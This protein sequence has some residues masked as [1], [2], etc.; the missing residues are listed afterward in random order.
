MELLLVGRVLT[1]DPARPEADA[2]AVRGGRVA[3]VGSEAACAREVPGAERIEVPFLSPGFHDAHTHFVDHGVRLLRMRLER[4]ASREEVLRSVAERAKMTPEGG[5]VVGYGWDESKWPDA[6]MPTR[7]DLDRAAPRHPVLLLR[8]D[9]HMA[10]ANSEAMKRAGVWEEDG[11]LRE[12]KAYAAHDSVTPS[13]ETILKG[14]ERA[15]RE[16]WSLG[17]T[18]VHAVVDAE[19]VGVLREAWQAGQLG[20]R[21]GLILREPDAYAPGVAA[22]G[23]E[24]LRVLGVKLFTDGS[25][26]S[27]TAAVSSGYADDR[28]HTGELVYEQE[29]LDQLVRDA[30]ARGLQPALHAIGDLGVSAALKAFRR[31]GVEPRHRARIEHLELATDEQLADAR[32]MGVVASVQPNFIGEWGHPGQMYEQRLGWDV[33]SQLNRLRDYADARVHLAFGSDHMPYG[34]LRGIH[35]AV[36]GP[37]P[38]HRLTVDEAL[39]A[40]TAGSAYAGFEEETK[41][42]LAPGFLADVVGLDADPRDEPSAIRERRVVLTVVGGRVVHR[43]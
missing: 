31:A 12:E 2:V 30:V 28:A 8:V 38:A 15:T 41:G 5:W 24:H 3:A 43:G 1:Q 9:M 29:R 34:P 35:D 10:A 25:I 33:A 11:L 36:N 39:A 13:R 14:V 37:T 7:A 17:V 19:Q 32:A 21:V 40:Y 20:V 16:S 42:R 26:G 22:G 23:D 27:R 6:R 18:S 4:A